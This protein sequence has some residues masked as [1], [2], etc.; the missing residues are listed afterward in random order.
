MDPVA[1]PEGTTALQDIFNIHEC[2]ANSIVN[3]NEGI[4]LTALR[5]TSSPVDAGPCSI[6]YLSTPCPL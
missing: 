5:E 4:L 6:Q 2:F 1:G 3:V